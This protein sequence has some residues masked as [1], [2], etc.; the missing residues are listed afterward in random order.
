[1]RTT[2]YGDAPET[3]RQRAMQA[4]ELT[5]INNDMAGKHQR[6]KLLDVANVG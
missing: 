6:S 3:Q 2:L 1:M 4:Q 5:D